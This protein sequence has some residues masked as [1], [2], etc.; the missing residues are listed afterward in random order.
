VDRCEPETRHI[1][2]IVA[3]LG[4]VPYSAPCTFPQTLKIWRESWGMNQEQMAAVLDVDE[5]TIAYWERGDHK[6]VGNS[7]QKIKRAMFNSVPLAMDP[8][9]T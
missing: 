7:I 3:F 8:R 1:P 4:Y 5:S 9:V 6:P 2:A